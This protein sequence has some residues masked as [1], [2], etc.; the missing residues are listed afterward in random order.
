MLRTILRKELLENIHSYR[1][2]LFALIC[3]VLIPLGMSVNNAQY[4][5]RLKDYN[6]QVRLADEAQSGLKIQDLMA[7]RVTIKG[8]RPPSQLSVFS[9]GL[10]SALPAY[11]QF[12][13]DGFSQ[14]ESSSSDATL[15]STQGKF[16]LVFLIQ[17]VISLVG[18]LFASD[19]ISGEKESGTLRAMLSNSL[20]RDAILVGK[21]AGGYLALLAPFLVALVL[22]VMLLLPGGFPLFAGDIPARIAVMAGAAALFILIYYVI[23]TMV[24]ATSAKARTSLVAILL[25]WSGFQ[26]V[27]PKLSDIAASLIHPVRT[28]T[29]VSLEK[30]LLIN[31]LETESAK[32]LGREYDKIFVGK[33]GTDAA[34]DQNSPEMKKWAPIRDEMQLKTREKKAAQ[35]AAIDETFLAQQR[36]QRKLAAALSLISPSSAFAQLAADLCGTGDLART[37]YIEAVRSHQNALENELFSKVKRTLM[38]HDNGRTTMMFSAQPVDPKLLPKF[39]VK[40]ASLGEALKANTS[41][42]LALLFWLIAPFAFAYVKFLRYDVR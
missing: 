2:P 32:E 22:G 13:Q 40:P 9:Q 19:M 34:A 39:A 7:G 29:Q 8:F 31:T 3:V 38:M 41:S 14:G 11:Y 18:L 21:I 5:K 24:S 10:E 35:L 17:M 1:F 28:D 37:K 23:G 12:A 15:T 20:P 27:I 42:L 36:R 16:D 25:I 30:S 26:L 4:A 6:E 33:A